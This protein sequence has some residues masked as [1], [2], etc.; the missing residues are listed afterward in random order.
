[1]YRERGRAYRGKKI[2][3]EVSGKR[4]QRTNIIAGYVNK[5]TIAECMYKVNTDT[6]FFNKWI[7]EFLIPE[8]KPGQVIVMDNATFHKNKRTQELIERAGYRLIYLPPYSPDLN[9]IERFWSWLKRKIRSIMSNFT[10]L[11][12]VLSYIAAKWN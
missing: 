6:E 8:L 2:I 5:R 9:P 4:Y 12:E 10:S 7:E 1:M 3:G 11:E